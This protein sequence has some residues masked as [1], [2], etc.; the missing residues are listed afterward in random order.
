MTAPAYHGQPHPQPYTADEVLSWPEDGIRHEVFDGSLYVSPHASMNHQ[1]L[2]SRLIRALDPALPAGWEILAPANLRLS[3]ARLVV[4][5]LL[6]LSHVDRRAVAADPADVRLIVEV[7]S[8]GNASIDRMVKP[9]L[10]AE[11]GI[12]HFWLFDDLAAA[13]G[14]SVRMFRLP[15]RHRAAYPFAAEQRGVVVVADPFQATIDLGGLLA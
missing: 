11:A 14:P 1:L 7:V 4:P 15:L 9:S 13:D 5:D 6:V 3:P 12:E 8:S 2:L 10:Y